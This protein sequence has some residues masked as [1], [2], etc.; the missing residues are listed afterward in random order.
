MGIQTRSR[1]TE[2]C[3]SAK[4]RREPVEKVRAGVRVIVTATVTVTA[5]VKVRL[6]SVFWFVADKARP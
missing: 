2:G 3:Q 1:R 6:G 5:R 4:D